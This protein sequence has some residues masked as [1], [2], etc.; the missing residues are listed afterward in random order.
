ML[1]QLNGKSIPAGGFVMK[2]RPLSIVLIAL[3]YFIQP[4][5]NV[6]QAAF[7]NNLPL[8][9][10]GGILARLLWTDWI[11]LGLFPIVGI[12]IYKVKRWGWYLFICFSALLILYN[13]AVYFFLNPNYNLETVLFFIMIITAISALFLRKHV[14][15]PYFNPRLRWWETARRYRVQ[16]KTTIMTSDGV[17]PCKT[18]DISDSGAFVECASDFKEG[19]HVWLNL[20]CNGIE[21]SCLGKVVRKS[22]A[23]ENRIGYGIMFL[24]LSKDTKKKIRQLIWTLER[25]EYKERKDIIP[26]SAIPADFNRKHYH[27]IAQ[28]GFR[29]KASLKQVFSFA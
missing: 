28:L 11:I 4:I 27:Q 10:E 13:L 20:G 17:S 29:L 24:D 23:K 5:G 25:L 12:G 3:F 22:E 15:A 6:V 2:K 14:Y 21:I 19:S 9:G 26:T 8:L 16:L 7:V 1:L 18:M